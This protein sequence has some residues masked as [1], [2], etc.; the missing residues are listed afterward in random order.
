MDLKPIVEALR[1]ISEWPW[2]NDNTAVGDNSE[3]ELLVHSSLHVPV[4]EKLPNAAFIASSPRWLAQ[5]MIELVE[6]RAD[7]YAEMA[8]PEVEYNTEKAR[9]IKAALNNFNLTLEDW[10]WLK[11]KVG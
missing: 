6:E 1:A 11:E 2:H 9:W 4:K 7:K 10:T 5:L 3:L 8:V